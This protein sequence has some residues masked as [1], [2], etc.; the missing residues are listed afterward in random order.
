MRRLA[1]VLLALIALQVSAGELPPCSPASAVGSWCE[2]ELAQLRPSQPAV[3]YLQVEDEVQ[4]LSGKSEQA[5]Q[6]HAEKKR[7]PV[8][9]GPGGR[10]Y[11]VDRHHLT[12]AL[13][14]L[15]LKTAPVQIEGRLSDPASFWSEMQ[16]RHWAWLK[17]EHGV[18]VDPA[19][20]PARVDQLPDSPYRSLAGYAR[21]AGYY[22]KAGQAFFVEFAWAEYLRRALA[23]RRIS[24]ATLQQDLEAARAP[25]CALAAQGLPGYPG[26]AC[27]A[28]P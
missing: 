26:K 27:T 17:D 3:G 5:L 7:I 20:L 22:R 12:T 13:L 24:R 2:I 4:S 9:H 18:A 23:N 21:D 8:V 11:L 19:V 15:K 10:F 25:A 16:Q 6:R 1:G 14:R 28:K